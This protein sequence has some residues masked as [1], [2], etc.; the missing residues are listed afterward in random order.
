[1]EADGLRTERTAD[2]LEGLLGCTYCTTSVWK[3]SVVLAQY[4]LYGHGADS[5]LPMMPCMWASA[6]DK[7]QCCSGIYIAKVP[8]LSR[9]QSVKDAGWG[10]YA[11][12]NLPAACFIGEYAGVVQD[13]SSWCSYA[14]AYQSLY[15]RELGVCAKDYGNVVRCINHSDRPNVTFR[16]MIHR[17]VVR[18][19]CVTIRPVLCGEQLLVD[20]GPSYWAQADFS[21]VALG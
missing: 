13:Q 15:E 3:S 5:E 14:C 4:P 7:G 9:L 18:V 6:L 20:Y 17:D 21:P 10:V 19:A 12:R 8:A 11:S 1:M 16:Q 2:E